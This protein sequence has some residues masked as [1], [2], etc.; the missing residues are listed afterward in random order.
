MTVANLTYRALGDRV[1]NG[2]YRADV[3]PGTPP[4]AAPIFR[5]GYHTIAKQ[6]NALGVREKRLTSGH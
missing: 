2:S 3:G 5:L 1:S 6:F 4:P